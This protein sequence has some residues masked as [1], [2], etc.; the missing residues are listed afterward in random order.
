MRYYENVLKTSENRLNPRSYYIPGGKSEYNLLNGEWRFKYYNRDIDVEENIDNWDNIPVPSCWQILGYEN[1]NYTNINY[2]YPYDIPYV[3]DD[4][5]CGV[6]ERDFDIKNKWG[7]VY[8]VLE[9]VSSCAKIFLNG[10]YVGF[11]Q[12]S[13]LEAEFDITDFVFEGKN[14]IRVEVLKWCV[15]SYLEDQDFMRFNGIFRDLYIL[16]RPENHIVDISLSTKENSIFVSAD[17]EC[18]ISLYSEDGNLLDSK[19]GEKA[20]FVLENPIRWNAEMPYLYTVKIEKDGEIITRKIGFRAISVSDKGEVLLNGSPI[21]FRGVNHHDTSKMRGWCQSDE[22]LL[23]DLRLMKELNI[24]CIRTSHYPPT[25]KFVDMCDELGFYV[26][27]ETDL[28]THGIVRRFADVAYGYDV[29]SDDWVCQRDEWKKEFIERMQRAVL[30]F[31]NNTCVVM[32]STGNESGY[33]KNHEAMIDWVRTLRDDRL[34]HCEDASRKG[35]NAKADVYSRMYTYMPD[36]EKYA[37]DEN[38]KKP[39]FLCE[40]AHAMGNGPGDVYDYNELINK[41]PKL[42]GGCIW[43]WADHVVTEDG[44]EKYGGDFKG[45]LTHDANFCCDGIV[46]ADRSFKAGTLEMKTAYQPIRT[47]LSGKTLTIKNLYDFTVL[48]SDFEFICE[49][50]KDGEVIESSKKELNIKPH[51]NQEIELDLPNVSSKYGLYLNCYL[52]KNG[53]ELAHTQHKLESQVIKEAV[54][55]KKAKFSEIGENILISGEGFE[56]TFSKFYGNFISLKIAGEEKLA[57]RMGITTW[58]APIDNERYIKNKWG[59]YNIWEGEN[60]DCLFTKIYDC[61]LENGVITVSGSLSGVSRMPFFRYT[62]TIEVFQDGRINF[63]LSGIVREN[64]FWLPRLGFELKLI[65]E[66]KKFSYFGNGP[67]ESYIDMCHAGKI[68]RYESSADKEYVKYPMPQEHGNHIGVR[69]LLIDGMKFTSDNDFECNVSNY[70]SKDLTAA[71]H[72]DELTKK[73]YTFVRLD[74][75]NSGLGSAACGPPLEEKYRLDEKKIKFT[76]SMLKM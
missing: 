27:L 48:N 45:E 19:K 36:M 50:E 38:E 10:K 52:L 57:E 18:N 62:L 4:N 14:T 32:W 47:F 28:E 29:E 35:D 33:G 11:T 53:F 34:V 2:P 8:F 16:Q 41:Y 63:D 56:Y 64:V 3:P 44:V 17:K 15:G 5:P 73:G 12:G 20:E 26:V 66:D 24:N 70:S 37:L 21:K 71:M 69:E 40:Y 1:P 31:K 51:S 76:F 13:H 61:K 72:T 46:F 65:G 9:G 6:Y 59:N 54:C 58:R 25:P 39:F 7:R 74:Y 60:M 75:K 43:E 68:G 30:L 22:E 67:Y 55:E 23:N 42:S 49:I